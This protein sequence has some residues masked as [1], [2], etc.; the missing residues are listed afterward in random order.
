MNM[1]H[2]P[3]LHI[4]TKSVKEQ[5]VYCC[6]A[7]HSHS[8]SHFLRFL[9]LTHLHLSISHTHIN[10]HFVLRNNKTNVFQQNVIN[11]NG[12]STEDM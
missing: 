8:I 12:V 6:S 3:T 9:N 7:F 4:D 2:Y 5:R 1:P 10:I 11:Q